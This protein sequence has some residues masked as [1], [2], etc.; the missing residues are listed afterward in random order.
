MGPHVHFSLIRLIAK[1]KVPAYTFYA[2]WVGARRPVS[3]EDCFS[4]PILL[5]TGV[6]PAVA[7]LGLRGFVLHLFISA[8]IGVTYGLLFRNEAATL[9]HGIAWGWIFGLIWWYAGPLTLMP[10]ILTG[11]CD[12]STAAA[13]ALLPAMMGH[14]IYGAVTALVF[15]ILARRY[16]RWLLL[17]PRIAARE[18]RKT[19]PIGTPAP[20]LWFFVLGLGVLLPI[21]LG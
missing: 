21:L 13:S 15:L 12:W 20:A 1:S 10:L 11:E 9:G 8:L 3:S 17:D 6:F 7:G 5:V 2:R 14:L 4:S 16:T 19:R 18:A